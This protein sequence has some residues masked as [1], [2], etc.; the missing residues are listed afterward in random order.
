MPN[1]YDFP[2]ELQPISTEPGGFIVPNRLAVVRT[3]TMRPIGIVSKKYALLPH[4]D[5]IDTLRES[6]K[7]QE[8]QKKVVVTHGG[9]RMYV[10]IILPNVTL[11]VEGDEIAMRLVV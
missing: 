10:E 3:D 5:V 9:A 2:V 6:F 7:G 1:D 8:V 11:K 4:A